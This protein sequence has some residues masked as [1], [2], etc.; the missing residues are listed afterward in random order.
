MTADKITFIDTLFREQTELVD[1]LRQQGQ[2]SFAQ[3]VEAIL[4]KTL[5]LSVASYFESRI[6][7]SIADYAARI[8]GADEALTSL[9]R[10]KAIERQYH[11]YFSWREGGRSAVPFF[12]MLGTSA[13]D[14]AKQDMKD[15]ELK[16]AVD[17]FLEL[18]DLR[19]LLVHEN[20]G[21]YPLEMTSEEIYRQ[22]C[23][24]LRFVRYVEEK[25]N[26]VPSLESAVDQ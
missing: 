18:G 6:T 26:P 25:L 24:A 3:N 8:S 12:A 20:F 9:V 22:Y 10:I 5:L 15:K 7:T 2:L 21:S 1:F 19:N 13:K 4:S 11:T 16:Q 17:A 14:S 23:A